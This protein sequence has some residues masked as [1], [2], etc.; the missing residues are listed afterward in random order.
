MKSFEESLKNIFEINDTTL[1]VA[2]LSALGYCVAYIF[3]LNY[4]NYFNV[5]SQF[6]QIDLI[7]TLTA[8]TVTVISLYIVISIYGLALDFQKQAH[9][10]AQ[11]I[12]YAISPVLILGIGFYLNTWT[13]IIHIW[14]LVSIF[15]L[16]MLIQLL[17]PL[18]NKNLSTYW[19][20]VK[21]GGFF[22]KNTNE[23][24]I[25]PESNFSKF[26]VR[27]LLIFYA[28]AFIAGIA[29]RHAKNETQFLTLKNQPELVIIR[30]YGDTIIAKKIDLATHT[31]NENTE[32][33]KV[34]AAHLSI[35]KSNVDF[36]LSKKD[37]EYYDK[38]K[39]Y[40]DKINEGNIFSE[41]E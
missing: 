39:E 18:L 41:L 22:S 2:F 12:G 36:I 4:L 26:M 19:S 21:V 34:D 1:L 23:A 20:R 7:R 29:S 30:V 40:L 32:I 6:I 11:V 8:T 9:P 28:F 24:N 25:K 27:G 33:F 35:I 13:N 3:E 15:L 14:I 37:K 38:N 10:F 31:T 16:L 17:P 5:P